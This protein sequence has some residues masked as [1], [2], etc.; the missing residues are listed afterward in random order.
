[1]APE[2][3]PIDVS[4]IPELAHLADE[5]R[6]TRRPRVIRRADEDLA[7][8]APPPPALRGRTKGRVL[9]EDDPLFQLVG[10]GDSGIPGGLSGKKYEALGRLRHT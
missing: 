9:T 8:L 4:V 6:R 5:V 3:S 10:I 7:V 1:M 2:R